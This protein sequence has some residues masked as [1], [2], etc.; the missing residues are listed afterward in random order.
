MYVII[1][2]SDSSLASCLFQGIQGGYCDPP[3]I[4]M[5]QQLLKPKP[6]LL[7][8]EHTYLV[9][10][11]RLEHSSSDG[12]QLSEVALALPF[13]DVDRKKFDGSY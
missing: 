10:R 12:A 7:C 8:H 4:G 5:A 6:F 13:L 9:P 1:K 2:R 3:T 11:K